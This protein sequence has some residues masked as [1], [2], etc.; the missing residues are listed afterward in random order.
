ME[1]RNVIAT[2]TL[3]FIRKSLLLAAACFILS[4]CTLDTSLFDLT[5][6]TG[7]S[8]LL[9]DE[10]A[11]TDNG[12]LT[13]KWIPSA[14]AQFVQQE[15]LFFKG[16]TCDTPI[17]PRIQL[18]NTD[19]TATAGF[20]KEDSVQYTFR[21]FSLD[22]AGKVIVSSCSEPITYVAAFS[23][24]TAT[25]GLINENNYT[26]VPFYGNCV[27]GSSI[28]VST[29]TVPAITSFTCANKTWAQNLD[30]SGLTNIYNGNL[31][32]KVTAPGAAAKEFYYVIE[33]DID[34]PL[35]DIT[36]SPG[37][38]LANQTNYTVSGTCSEFGKSV[39]LAIGTVNTSVDCSSGTF[40]K[41]LDVS[42]L[43]GSPVTITATHLD[44]VLNSRSDTVNVPRSVVPPTVTSFTINNDDAST[45]Y[46]AVTLNIAATNATEMYITNSAGCSA[47]GSWQ[48]YATTENWTLAASDVTNVVYAK[49]RDATGNE[50]VCVTDSIVHDSGLATPPAITFDTPATATY[51]NSSNVTSFTVGGTCNKNNRSITFTGPGG[52]TGTGT[53]LGTS[54]T[55]ILDLSTIAQGAFTL[56]ATLTDSQGNSASANSPSYTKDTVAPTGTFSINNGATDTLS[57]SAT[58]NSSIAGAAQMYITNT[59]GCS[60]DG[61]W[62]AYAAFK[63]WTLSTA[64]A[65]NT[66]YARYRDAAGNL[67]ACLSDTITHSSTAPT[68]S[69]ASPS[70]G[71]YINN[72]NKASFTVSGACSENGKVVTVQPTGVAAQTPT[73]TSGAWTATFNVTSPADGSISFT[74]NHSRATGINAPQVTASFTKDTVAPTLSAVA[75]NSGDALT[76]NL[77]VNLTATT[78]GTEMYITN[79]ALCLTGGTW[80]TVAF[81]KAWTL[82]T[83]NTTNTIYIK[84]RDTAQNESSCL[85]DFIIHDNM[86]PTLTITGPPAGSYVNMYNAA[87][88]PITG[89]CSESGVLIYGT[90]DGQPAA[91]TGATYCKD[92]YFTMNYNIFSLPETAATPYTFTLS[93]TRANGNVV[94]AS[95]YYYYDKTPPAAVT[96]SGAPAGTN[97]SPTLNVT[98]NGTAASYRY[99]II[100]PGGAGNCLS[101]YTGTSYP[102][103]TPITDALPEVGN[104]TLCVLGFDDHENGAMSSTSASWT[105]DALKSTISGFP[106]GVSTTATLNV[107]VAGTNITQYKYAVITSGTCAAASYFAAAAVAAPIAYNVSALP[108]GPVTLC[109]IGGDTSNNFQDVAVAT[110]TS[111]IKDSVV[112]LAITSPL[113][114]RVQEGET[115]NITFTLS[116]SKTFDVIGYY[117]V[118]GDAT[119][120]ER[121]LTSGSFTIPA[122]ST[123]VSVPVTFTANPAVTGERLMNVHMTHTNSPAVWM[124][125]KYQA[126]YFIAD[127][128]KNLTALSLAINFAHGCVVL[129]DNSLRCW[130]HN[131]ATGKLGLGPSAPTYLDTAGQV[132]GTNW[133]TVTTGRNHTCALTTDGYVYCWGQ[134]TYYQVGNNSTT[135]AYSPVAID[136]ST[137][138]QSISAGENHTCGLTTDKKIKCWG[139]SD[140][141][142]T[143]YATTQQVPAVVDATTDYKFV[144]ANASGTCG[145]TEGKKLYCWGKGTSWALGDT[146]NVTKG[147]PTAIDATNDY[148]FVSMGSHHSC[149]IKDNGGL[150]CWGTN[151]NGQVGD[152]TTA[153]KSAPV[154]INSSTSY[155]WVWTN[156]DTTAVTPKGTTCA[157]TDGNVLQCWGV[158]DK[159]QLGDGTRT[160]SSAPITAD[161]GQAYS[162]AITVGEK[163]CGVTLQGAVKCWG[164]L[165]N[166]VRGFA[167]AGFGYGNYYAGYTKISND[168][169]SYNFSSLGF[170][171]LN[172]EGYAQ[173]C[174]ISTG[175]L[176]CWGS[177]GGSFGDGTYVTRRSGPVMMDPTSN[178][179]ALPYQHDQMNNCAI[180]TLGTLKCWG[181]NTNGAIGTAAAVGG[182][183]S[184]PQ[185]ADKFNSYTSAVM[186]GSA[187]CAITTNGVLR[188]TGS[189]TTGKLGDGTTTNISEFKTIDAGVYYR[190][191]ALGFNYGCGI[192][193]DYHL[194]CWGTNAVGQLGT[195]NTTTYLTPTRIDGTETY[196][197]ISIEEVRACAITTGNKLKCW[198]SGA[199]GDGTSSSNVPKAIDSATDYSDISI[200]NN[201]ACGIRTDGVA[202]CWGGGGL[203]SIPNES[204][205]STVYPTPLIYDSGR[206][207]SK[208]YIANSTV[209]GQ[210]MDGSYRCAGINGGIFGMAEPTINYFSSVI[211][212]STPAYIHKWLY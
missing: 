174:G 22:S 67:T 70:A 46:L 81:P 162:K 117:R 212:W 102:L 73:C 152:G 188:C 170:S 124:D 149:A 187:T 144:T 120:S 167:T 196:K 96:L 121:S 109:V 34:P 57:L 89:T 30:L 207:Y 105:R 32:F 194:K 38:N 68:V 126:Q 122:G 18:S 123:S 178:Y 143:G 61:V 8:S 119:S 180:T 129:S 198:G 200:S 161:A 165:K 195:G 103:S 71:T 155:I 54:Y 5:S 66:V 20:A 64:D 100:P 118:T 40:T 115:K 163:T 208:I 31:I 92:G 199:L 107:T 50:S 49:F 86:M 26:A 203:L 84:T 98:V 130:G 205:S 166:D 134:N 111:W 179:S 82:A 171:Y 93:L 191:V 172:T 36:S 110:E 164:Q 209:C 159:G 55:A 190:H 211:I 104:Y 88:F 27:N 145:I 21:I 201:L 25:N 169:G 79:N 133:A 78:T 10:D 151:T 99:F 141:S 9:W 11:L 4:A 197:A 90:V 76:A 189:N 185:V 80:E 85:S 97:G 176:Y 15:V 39:S 48:T 128:E 138:Y 58:I 77:N 3:R 17:L 168:L 62:E 113:V 19:T 173:T 60:S 147:I 137:T 51:V 136:T 148:K 210:L 65:V 142:Q 132:A 202:K 186:R 140:Y 175:K 108:N 193:S 125:A 181:T 47:G 206:A 116:G 153:T 95:S 7:A 23:I 44:K 6:A 12:D 72:A 2:L 13:A 114:N 43:T 37:I 101:G 53:C 157:I 69:L 45:G 91:G 160:N 204:G 83:A 127:A 156:D 150:R 146:T 158:N 87:S 131:I 183:A 41:T 112:T 29:L 75:I 139:R 42:G 24:N 135:T 177:A 182:S 63:V 154:D 56:T 28:E 52:W 14:D 106:T 1:Q 184:T 35:I 16:P 59:A 74:V 33:K 94:T 192:T